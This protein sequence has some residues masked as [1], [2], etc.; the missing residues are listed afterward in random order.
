[1]EEQRRLKRRHL[2]FYLR[3]FD[4]QNDQLMGYLIDL[5]PDGIL[6]MTEEKIE[7]GKFF[8][9]RMDLPSE[10]SDIQEIEFE[11]ESVWGSRDV[12]PDFQDIG[13]RLHNISV[14]ER[15][16]IEDLIEDLGFEDVD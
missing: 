3:V 1:M 5:T 2:I 6:L 7:I 8:R 15:Q 13:F 14:E 9:L 11:A 4:M 16:I 10:Y 12:N